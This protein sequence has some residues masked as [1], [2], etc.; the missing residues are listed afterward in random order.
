MGA[1]NRIAKPTSTKAISQ[2]RIQIMRKASIK[3]TLTET[4]TKVMMK[5]VIKLMKNANFNS[6]VFGLFNFLN[7]CF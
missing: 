1:I 5:V 2:E 4:N 7:C 3:P 6:R